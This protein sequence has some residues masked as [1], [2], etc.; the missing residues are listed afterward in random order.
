MSF[1]DHL[2]EL[3]HRLIVSAVA[4]FV[5]FLVAFAFIGRIFE[6]I[7][8]PLQQVLRPAAS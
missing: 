2:E 7:M 4:I 1:L 8:R 3:R 6:F 5:G